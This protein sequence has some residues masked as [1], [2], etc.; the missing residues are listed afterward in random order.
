MLYQAYQLQSDLMSPMRL[1]A[2]ATSASLWL[3]QT[4]GSMLRKISAACE[5]MSRMRLT[6]SRP[7]Y[8]ITS[9]TVGDDTWPVTEVKTLSLPFG[10]LLHFK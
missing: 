3:R 4:E 9:V 2:Q 8:G 7:A 6:H 10:T 5:V 1:L